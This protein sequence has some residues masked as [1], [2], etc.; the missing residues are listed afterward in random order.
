MKALLGLFIF[1]LA[2]LAL[3]LWVYLLSRK[4]TPINLPPGKTDLLSILRAYR[5]ANGNHALPIIAAIGLF[6][7]VAVLVRSIFL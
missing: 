5:Q 7:L 6:W 1:V 3:V 4:Q 2:P